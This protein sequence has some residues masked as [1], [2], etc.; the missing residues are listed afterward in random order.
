MRTKVYI[1]VIEYSDF[2][3]ILFIYFVPR[4][5]RVSVCYRIFKL[6]SRD[7]ESLLFESLR[8]GVLSISFFCYLSSKLPFV[9]TIRVSAS[10]EKAFQAQN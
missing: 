2:V 9:S 6:E 4:V 8:S 1:L 3:N 7:L 10:S 5:S